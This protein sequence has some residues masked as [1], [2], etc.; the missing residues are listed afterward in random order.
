MIDWND[1]A[2]AA[3][4]EFY[5]WANAMF[6]SGVSIDTDTFFKE[7]AETQTKTVAD[8]VEYYNGDF[9]EWQSVLGIAYS[10]NKITPYYKGSPIADGTNSP[11]SY[12]ICTRAEFEAYVK[13][14]EG[15]KWT[16]TYSDYGV[17]KDC[18]LI[19][20]KPDIHGQVLVV[21]RY[22]EYVLTGT[23]EPKPIKPTISEA[24]LLHKIKDMAKGVASDGNFGDTVRGWLD[25]YDII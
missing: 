6:K 7:F 1:N 25:D 16:H 20:D 24:E 8:A 11:E 18:I 15:E 14:Q 9:P 4:K 21:N 5:R 13:E 3:V 12:I 23:V 2:K 19:H 22:D 10:N 17:R